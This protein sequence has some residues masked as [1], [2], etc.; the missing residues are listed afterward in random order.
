MTTSPDQV[1]PDHWNA[2]LVM[3]VPAAIGAADT[4]M[5]PKR[6]S[7]WTAPLVPRAWPPSATTPTFRLAWAAQVWKARRIS[8]SQVAVG[9]TA[10][11][12]RNRLLLELPTCVPSGTK[13]RV[14]CWLSGH[15][16]P[17]VDGA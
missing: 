16:I 12:V 14:R 2:V 3:S 7:P 5:S 6:L 11:R 1:V 9:A 8:R 15:A 10:L 17:D 13:L 4:R